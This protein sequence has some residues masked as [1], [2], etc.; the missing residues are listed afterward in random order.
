MYRFIYFFQIRKH[1]SYLAHLSSLKTAYNGNFELKR[2]SGFNN[3][4]SD[5]ITAHNTPEDIHHNCLYLWVTRDQFESFS[6]LNMVT[7]ITRK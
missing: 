5:N 1:A 2:F 6:H 7:K 3:S 4:F